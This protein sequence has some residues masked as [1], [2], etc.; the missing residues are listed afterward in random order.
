M[1]HIVENVPQVQGKSW[2]LMAELID[3]MG[4]VDV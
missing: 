4:F 1:R 2:E 3:D